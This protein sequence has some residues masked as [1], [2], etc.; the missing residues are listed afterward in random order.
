[1]LKRIIDA[2]PSPQATQFNWQCSREDIVGAV[3]QVFAA[4]KKRE[5]EERELLETLWHW[6]K[7]FAEIAGGALETP[8]LIG[9]VAGFAPFAAIG[10]GFMAAADEIKRKRASIGFAEGVVMGV[11]V[12]SPENLRDYFWEERPTPNPAFEAGAKIAQYYYNGGLALGYAF[13]RQVA[14][15]KLGGAFWSDV[16]HH[17]T[18]G[19]GDPQ[20]GWE[21]RDWIDFYTGTAGAFYRGH[22]RE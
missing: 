20:D 17:V 10:A 18:T 21:R 15:K 14:E 1:V 9:V 5:E 6:V 2:I 8:I 13:G 4:I 19:F 12:E 3:E 16:K 11:M 22:I 7:T